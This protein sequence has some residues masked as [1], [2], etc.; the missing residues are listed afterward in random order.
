MMGKKQPPLSGQRQRNFERQLNAEW[1]RW[2]AQERKQDAEHLK[3]FK[4][5][6]HRYYKDDDLEPPL[7]KVIK[8]LEYEHRHNR[9][10]KVSKKPIHWG[11]AGDSAAG[12]QA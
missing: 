9:K 1:R 3:Y 2:E 7:K 12:G 6:Y 4:E 8:G 5:L 10:N 11:V